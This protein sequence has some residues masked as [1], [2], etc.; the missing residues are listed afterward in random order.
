LQPA[1]RAICAKPVPFSMKK[2]KTFRLKINLIHTSLV[3]FLMRKGTGQPK[4]STGK[5]RKADK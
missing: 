5:N 1:G 2:C 3:S 4:F